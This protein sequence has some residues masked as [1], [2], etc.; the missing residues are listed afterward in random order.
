MS[1]Q[2]KLAVVL[3]SILAATGA[4]CGGNDDDGPGAGDG[5]VRVV[6]A[7]YPLAEAARQVG[8][9]VVAVDD[10][11]PAGVEPHDLEM[12]P[13][14]VDAIEDADV[15]LYVGGG[16]QP[17]V[18]EVAERQGEA[19]VD[20]RPAGG[21]DD[22]HFWLDPA[23]FGD[24]VERIGD[25]LARV[26]PADRTAFE[27]RAARFGDE[28]TA[29]DGDIRAA[30]TTCERRTIVTSHDAFGQLAARYDLQQEAIAGLSP[31]SEPDADRLAELADLVARTGVTTVFSEPGVSP[32]VGRTLAREAGVEVAVLDPLETAPRGGR[33]YV[34]VMRENAAA[35]AEALG[36]S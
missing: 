20:V 7:F 17:A 5:A 15:V 21:E 32:R 27:R 8:G 25:A 4:A 22:P 23:A 26:R 34:T 6:A 24:A 33:D 3:L 28:L 31:E 16:F 10:L 30:L 35:L 29:L 9:A 18:E 14:Q 36:C 1:L 13:G 2:G 11:T 12:T 19:A